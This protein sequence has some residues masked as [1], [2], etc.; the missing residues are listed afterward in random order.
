MWCPADIWVIVGYLTSVGGSIGRCNQTWIDSESCLFREAQ[1]PLFPNDQWQKEGLSLGIEFFLRALLDGG[2]P[3]RLPFRCFAKL[4]RFGISPIEIWGNRRVWD[5]WWRW[6]SI[7]RGR[8]SRWLKAGWLGILPWGENTKKHLKC[9]ATWNAKP[10][11]EFDEF[12]ESNFMELMN[13]T[14]RWS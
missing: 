2:N 10:Q 9:K 14:N 13:F 3:S 7:L 8:G 11:I 1:A 4:P 5:W 12:H 6:L